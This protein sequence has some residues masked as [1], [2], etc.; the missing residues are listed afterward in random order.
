MP[1]LVA[2]SLQ[3]G[4]MEIQ[5]DRE[6]GLRALSSTKIRGRHQNGV[7]HHAAGMQECQL[8]GLTSGSLH[9]FESECF[10]LTIRIGPGLSEA[11]C[12]C[13]STGFAVDRF[14]AETDRSGLAWR[15]S[16]APIRCWLNASL[17]CL[18]MC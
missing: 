6:R 12:L 16:N 2:I 11:E 9:Q 15:D 1:Y 13:K 4:P 18:S 14:N 7:R 17:N 5:Q 3:S 8:M 10:N